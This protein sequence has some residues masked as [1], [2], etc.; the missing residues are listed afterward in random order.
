MKFPDGAGVRPEKLAELRARIARL[1]INLAEIEEK[2]VSGSGHGG[3]KINR[4]R[5]CVQLKYPRRDI[6]IRCQRERGLA[7]NRFLA[8]RELADRVEMAVSPQTSRRLDEMR[9]LRKSKST[10]HARAVEKTIPPNPEN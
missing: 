6:I 9:R 7:L 3:Q 1:G 8:L 5:N 4:S 2:Y 10:L